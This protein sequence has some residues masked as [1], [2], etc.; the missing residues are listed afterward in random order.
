MLARVHCEN[1]PAQCFSHHQNA[2]LDPLSLVSQLQI[3]L[4]AK[5]TCL[6]FSSHR[7][8]VQSLA[9]LP[10]SPRHRQG[11]GLSS[12]QI[13]VISFAGRNA[14]QQR[15]TLT[16]AHVCEYPISWGGRAKPSVEAPSPRPIPDASLGPASAVPYHTT[17]L[18]LRHLQNP[19]TVHA[20]GFSRP[21]P[22]TY[23][24][25]SRRSL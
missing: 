17:S 4:L 16:L 11:C 19:D 18:A 12:K 5:H 14:L 20:R 13:Y 1:S 25:T 10:T 9:C 22:R 7:A 2:A 6:S 15:V 21:Q 8:T 3:V 24:R 23:A